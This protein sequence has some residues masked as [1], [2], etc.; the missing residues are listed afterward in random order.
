MKLGPIHARVSVHAQ[1]PDIVLRILRRGREKRAPSRHQATPLLEVGATIGKLDLVADGVRE[2]H[3]G[4]VG[5]EISTF[6]SSV[7]KR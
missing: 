7:T 6:G 4:D 1:R 2:R 5:G 3:L